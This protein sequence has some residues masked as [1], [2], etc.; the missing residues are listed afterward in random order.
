MF[1]EPR[2]LRFQAADPLVELPFQFLLFRGR[3]SPLRSEN[4]GQ[5]LQDYLLPLRDLQGV[6]PKLAGQLALRFVFAQRC[7]HHLGFEL[8]AVSSSFCRVFP[9]LHDRGFPNLSTGPKIGEQYT[10]LPAFVGDSYDG[11]EIQEGGMASLEFCRV[12]FGNVSEAEKAR[13]R[14]NLEVYC[15]QDTMGMVKSVRA[16]RDLCAQ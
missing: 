12:T 14:R 2:Q 7:Q 3:P 9:H 13:V 10:V 4:L 8:R 11:L 15:S 5:A 16:L 6:N 1:F